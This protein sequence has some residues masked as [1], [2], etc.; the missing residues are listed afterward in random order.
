M[1]IDRDIRKKTGGQRACLHQKAWAVGA[2]HRS[3]QNAENEIK[4]TEFDIDKINHLW[5]ISQESQE[6]NFKC[7][8]YELKS[9]HLAYRIRVIIYLQE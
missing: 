9:V 5:D 7:G 2:L 6:I 3:W 1:L 8:K 4:M